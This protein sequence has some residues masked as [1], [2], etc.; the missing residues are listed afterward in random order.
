M[1]A[2]GMTWLSISVHWC[3][4]TCAKYSCSTNSQKEVNQQSLSL[5]NKSSVNE[6]KSNCGGAER[7]WRKTLAN[8][9]LWNI[10]RN[11]DCLCFERKDYFSKLITEKAQNSSSLFSTTDQLPNTAPTPPQ[12]STAKCEVLTLFF[13]NKITSTGARINAGNVNTNDP[14]KPC[15]VTIERLTCMTLSELHKTVTE[16]SSLTSCIDPVPTAFF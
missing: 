5:V 3:F 11:H 9:L 7:K 13:N 12:S 4:V 15:I 8:S 14:S 1:A 2:V 10:Q 6:M 16:C